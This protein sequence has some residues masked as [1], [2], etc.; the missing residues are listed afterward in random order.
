[1]SYRTKHKL[2]S[3]SMLS[4]IVLAGCGQSPTSEVP[5]TY[6]ATETLAVPLPISTGEGNG[7]DYPQPVETSEALLTQLVVG[8]TVLAE[9]ATAHALLPTATMSPPPPTPERVSQRTFETWSYRAFSISGRVYADIRYD[10]D[11]V[12][13]LK[14]YAKANRQLADQ[15]AAQGSQADVYITFNRFVT[16]EEFRVWAPARGLSIERSD[17]RTMGPDGREGTLGHRAHPYDKEIQPLDRLDEFLEPGW[18]VRGVYWT[19]ATVDTARLP[20]LA[21]DSLVF[22]ADVT[23]NVARN[24][25]V[26]AGW[27]GAEEAS[28]SVNGGE[29]PF[30]SM[31]DLGLEHFAP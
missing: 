10:N 2:L 5:A 7:F 3:I 31:E 24:D 27:L 22:L 29:P 25:L 19:V 30:G 28:I 8:A 9:T 11:S 4:I 18:T 6:P 15:L 20:E 13:S 21:S 14:A 26:A 17:L 23:S 12:A 1:M 16:P